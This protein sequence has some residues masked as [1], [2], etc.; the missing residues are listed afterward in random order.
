MAVVGSGL[1]ATNVILVS[2]EEIIQITKSMSR[3][4]FKLRR[5]SIYNSK[6]DCF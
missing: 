2:M 6:K 3:E 1:T 5:S 4:N